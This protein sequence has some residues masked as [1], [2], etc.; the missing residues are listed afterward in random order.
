MKTIKIAVSGAL[1]RMGRRIIALATEAGDFGITDAVEAA[2]CP[3][4]GRPLAEYVPNAPA[5]LVLTSRLRGSPRVLIDFSSPKATLARLREAQGKQIAFVI[6]T[7]GFTDAQRRQIKTAS[8]RRPIL[9]ASNMSVGVNVL[10]KLAEL[11]A[12]ALGQDYDAEIVEAHHHHKKDAPSGT[13]LTL[14]QAVA[15]GKKLDPK[16][17][18]IYGRS[19]PTG[20]RP[21]DEIAIHAVRGGDIVGDHTLTFATTGER[22]ELVHRAQSRDTF[23][24]GAL[25]AARF[26]ARKRT[27]LYDFQDVI[28]LRK[29]AS[30]PPKKPKR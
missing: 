15:A 23:V 3:A 5:D 8:R 19:G 18:F 25:R 28:G 11:A 27:G 24:R 12:K 14:A 7:T 4:L 9:L 26:I 20:A 6:G 13:A 1:G 21:R 29:L 30:A 2:D 17:S 22:I 16:R 10:F